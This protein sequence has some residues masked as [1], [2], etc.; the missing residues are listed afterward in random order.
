MPP[1]HGQPWFCGSER[2]PVIVDEDVELSEDYYAEVDNIIGR[3]GRQAR[4][5]H[6]ASHNPEADEGNRGYDFQDHE[7]PRRRSYG[8]QSGAQRNPPLNGTH[9]RVES[10]TVNGIYLIPGIFVEL[11]ESLAI[12]LMLT[13]GEDSLRSPVG[14]RFVEIKAIW[15]AKNNNQ[16]VILRGLPY[17]RNHNLFGRL[18]KKKNEVCQILEV[19]DDDN[20]PEEEQS[21]VEIKPEQVLKTRTLIMTNK[22]FPQDGKPR[23]DPA[24][25][26]WEKVANFAPLTCRWKMRME[27]KDAAQRKAGRAYGGSLIRLAENDVLKDKHRVSDNKLREDWRG[28]T[29]KNPGQA[30]TPYAFGDMFCG[31]GGVSRGAVMAGLEVWLHLFNNLTPMCLLYTPY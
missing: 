27:S 2:H 15:I 30:S 26:T 3:V 6:P 18:E 11:R 17:T 28:P 16:S 20:R 21:L 1:D 8:R 29:G 10:I 12:G 23:F 25:N 31:A 19:D 4:G 5:D 9:R 13:I 22:L 7:L 24:F 14:A